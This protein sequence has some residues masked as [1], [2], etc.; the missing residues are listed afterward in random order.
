MGFDRLVN[1]L[2]GLTGLFGA[3]SAR[4]A[5]FN[6][7]RITRALKAKPKYQSKPQQKKK[8][9]RKVQN[10]RPEELEDAPQTLDEMGAMVAWLQQNALDRLTPKQRGFVNNASGLLKSRQALSPK[11]EQWLRAIYAQHTRRER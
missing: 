5:A 3:R 11:Q 9:Q 8:T 7:M 1:L 6:A 10:Y 2:L 4:G